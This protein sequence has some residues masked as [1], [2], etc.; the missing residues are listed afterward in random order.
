MH[1]PIIANRQLTYINQNN[2]REREREIERG[3]QP[4]KEE[5]KMQTKEC[6]CRMRDND[7]FCQE[8]LNFRE[9]EIVENGR[10]IC[11]YSKV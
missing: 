6:A 11:M 3:R 1:L 10:Y 4:K 9:N 7:A 8:K 5:K 2:K